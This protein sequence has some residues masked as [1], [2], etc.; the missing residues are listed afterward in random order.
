MGLGDIVAQTFDIKK[1]KKKKDLKDLDCK[2]TLIFS[3]LGFLVVVSY[4][5]LNK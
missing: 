4:F 1:Q 2:R 3:A 5:I